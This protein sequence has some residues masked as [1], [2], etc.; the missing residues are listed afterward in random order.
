[1][2]ATR[3]AF[4]PAA[5]LEVTLEVNPSTVERARLPAFRD[6]GV[7]RLSIGIQSFDDTVLRRLGRAHRAEE[8]RRTL[9]AAR[10]AGFENLSMDLIFAAPGQ[11]E[12]AL[13]RDLEELTAFAPEH[14]STYALTVESGTPFFRAAARGQLTLP[15][16]EE[17]ARMME[18]IEAALEAAGL[19]GYEI[20]SYARPGFESR[21]NRRYWERRAVLGLGVGAWSCEPAGPDAP[22]G[23]RRANVRELPA[24]LTQVETGTPADAV[25]REV[26]DAPT[27]RGEAAFLSLRTRIGLR[28]K[29]FTEEFGAPPR[30]FWGPEIARLVSGGL[31]LEA[32]SGDLRLSARGRLLSDSVFACFV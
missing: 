18:A 7:T 32:V 29:E 31:L 2:A 13:A 1:M 27:A 28:A 4:P 30:T 10:E 12:A 17:G 20:S 11:D 14:V 9:R 26:L 15:G 8:G 25:A 22:H 3:A 19:T 16:E 21:H 24:Y 6:A 5:E 23:A